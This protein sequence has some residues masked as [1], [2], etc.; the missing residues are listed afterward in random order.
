M[1]TPRTAHRAAMSLGAL[2]TLAACAAACAPRPAAEGADAG[3]GSGG[4]AYRVVGYYFAPTVGRGF[5]V[6]AVDGARLTHLNYAFG[7]ITPDGLAVL[8]NPCLDVGECVGGRTD[9]NPEPGGNFAALRRL[10]E[11]HPHL[12]AF[13]SIG[14]WGWSEHFSDA[15]VSEAARGRFVESTLDVFIRAHPGVFDGVDLD[16]EYPVA[17]GRPEN[18]T[19][20]EDRLNYTLL[21][22]EFRRALDA[23]GRSDGRRYELTI[24]APAGPAHLANFE[25]QRLGEMLDFINVMTY[26]YHTAGRIAHF[27]APLDAAAGDPTPHLHIRGTVDAFLS[28]GVP[29]HRLVLGVPFYGY[30]YGGVPAERDGLFQP[31]EVN[32]F[33]GP[34]TPRRPWVGAVRF[35]QIAGAMA[36]GFVRHW[37]P[38]AAVPWLYHPGH[39]TWITYDDAE[40]IQVKTDFVVERGLGG[41]MIWELSGDDG[42]L[43]PVISRRLGRR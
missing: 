40:S 5:P 8:G 24:A 28:A 31:A 23:Q 1:M 6:S 19:R 27:N 12:R 10:K 43:L 13:I 25:M 11:R 18:R 2:M 7:N 22:E 21:L 20:P 38:D 39:R 32:G 37:D 29:A 26:D 16:W 17:G 3:A 35:H 4:E 9:P 36:E 41:I 34:D 33:E 14:G 30:G 42:S 15:A